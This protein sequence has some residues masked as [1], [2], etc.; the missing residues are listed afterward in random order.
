MRKTTKPRKIKNKTRKGGKWK[1]NLF[2]K[3][4]GF[5]S[6]RSNDD[7]TPDDVKYAKET[8]KEMSITKDTEKILNKKSIDYSECKNKNNSLYYK[9]NSPYNKCLANKMIQGLNKGLSSAN[10]ETDTNARE[11]KIMRELNIQYNPCDTRKKNRSFNRKY[12][13]KNSPYNKCLD[14]FEYKK[15][16]MDEGIDISEC[17][18]TRNEKETLYDKFFK[19]RD[20]IFMDCMNEKIRNRADKGSSKSRSSSEKSTSFGH[21]YVDSEGVSHIEI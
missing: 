3:G 4:R 6:T 15:L 12:Y 9:R 16:L 7:F 1:I 2:G 10:T 11:N 18:K 19:N 14:R 8:L 13:H 5:E 21:R 17:V 20:R